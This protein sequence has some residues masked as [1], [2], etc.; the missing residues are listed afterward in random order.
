MKYENEEKY[1]AQTQTKT[2]TTEQHQETFLFLPFVRNKTFIIF[3]GA[4][5]H[6]LQPV[7]CSPRG[8]ST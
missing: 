8:L 7:T 6:P 1:V 4:A 5:G 2:K 3:K